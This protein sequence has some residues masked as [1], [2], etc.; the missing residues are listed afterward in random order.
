[1]AENK[2]EATG[3]LQ[4]NAD[5][6]KKG[7]GAYANLSRGLTTEELSQTGT[8]KLILNDLARA[9]EQIKT[10]EP[11]L[12]RYYAMLTSKSVLEEKLIKVKQAEILYSFCITAGGIIIGLSKIWYETHPDLCWIMITIGTLLISGGILFKIYYKK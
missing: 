9:E 3:K 8:Q 11:Y 7:S 2:D 1:M 10:L 5:P 6:D 12:E 4:P